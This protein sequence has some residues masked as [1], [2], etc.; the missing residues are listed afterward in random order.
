VVGGG[1]GQ[2][3]RCRVVGRAGGQRGGGEAGSC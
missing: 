2:L 1:T 3:F